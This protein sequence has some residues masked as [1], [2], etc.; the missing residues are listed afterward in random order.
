MIG[1]KS[2]GP[3][4]ASNCSS[5]LNTNMKRPYHR[6]R[7]LIT[8][9]AS[10]KPSLNT[11]K[12]MPE[13]IENSSVKE[14]RYSYINSLSISP[15]P[16]LNPLYLDFEKQFLPNNKRKRPVEIPKKEKKTHDS[17]TSKMSLELKNNTNSD[18]EFF[19]LYHEKEILN[20]LK[21]RNTLNKIEC[22]NDCP[23]DCF[24]IELAVRYLEQQL[25]NAVKFAE[26]TEAN[27][28]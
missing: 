23:T 1:R 20:D 2:A 21:Q 19:R 12:D 9:G 3:A 11:G 10:T 16:K 28:N 15:T 24:Q 18:S 27:D 8:S 17:K 4:L 22:D 7:K 13:C 25:E 5:L 26:N 6:A 14:N